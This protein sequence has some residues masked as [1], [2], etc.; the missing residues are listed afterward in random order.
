MGQTAG[1]PLSMKQN[2]NSYIHLHK[3]FGLC[4]SKY[5]PLQ[6]FVTFQ[7]LRL[8]NSAASLTTSIMM[9]PSLVWLDRF[10]RR[11]AALGIV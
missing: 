8:Y 9:I 3:D 11:N 10:C 7:L 1:S 2:T 6:I 5:L 4:P